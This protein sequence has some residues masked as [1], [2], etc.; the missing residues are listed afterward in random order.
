MRTWWFGATGDLT[1]RKLIPALS[2]EEFRESVN[3]LSQQQP[4]T[5]GF[6]PGVGA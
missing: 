1:R 3:T 4:R 6:L 5:G 2:E